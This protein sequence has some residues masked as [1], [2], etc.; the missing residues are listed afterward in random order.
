M[1]TVACRFHSIQ[2]QSSIFV[3]CNWNM[4]SLVESMCHSRVWLAS[5]PRLSKHI[6]YYW[7][8]SAN[9]EFSS[10]CITINIDWHTRYFVC[11]RVCHCDTIIFFS[12]AICFHSASLRYFIFFSH[13]I[14]SFVSLVWITSFNVM[15]EEKMSEERERTKYLTQIFHCIHNHGK[16]Q[17]TRKVDVGGNERNFTLYHKRTSVYMAYT[18]CAAYIVCTVHTIECFN[19]TVK[20]IHSELFRWDPLHLEYTWKWIYAHRARLFLSIFSPSAQCRISLKYQ[21]IYL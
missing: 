13:S 17:M 14:C 9:I 7:Q 6:G 19:P 5:T 3:E 21:P 2:M 18:T 11:T 10:C 4:S 8:Y 12:T 1:K 16:W 15:R 20:T